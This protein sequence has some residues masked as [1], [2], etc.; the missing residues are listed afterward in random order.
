M[1]TRCFPILEL[2]REGG[3]TVGKGQR[4]NRALVPQ[5]TQALDNFKYEVAKDLGLPLPEGGYWGDYPSR[6]C[7]AMGG[8]MVRR[9][10]EMA[11]RSLIGSAPQGQKPGGV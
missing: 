3:E 2:D 9:M 6:D 4:S 11:E 7:G 5:A 8:H 1:K 10:I